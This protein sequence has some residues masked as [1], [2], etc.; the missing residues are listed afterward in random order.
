MSEQILRESFPTYRGAEFKFSKLWRST[1]NRSR[2]RE[3]GHNLG[4]YADQVFIWRVEKKF[5]VLTKI[6]DY[7][8]EPIARHGGFDFYADGFSLNY[9]NYVYFGLT[10]LAPQNV[11]LSLLRAYQK[12]SRTP[13]RRNLHDLH[14]DLTRL[15][16]EAGDPMKEF[17]EFMALGARNFETFFDIESFGGSDELQLTSMIAIVGHWRNLHEED[18]A[19]THD[20][21][22]NFFRRLEDWEKI[23]NSN[24]PDQD[25]PTASGTMFRFPL[26]VV[27]IESVDSKT[28]SSVQLCDVLSGLA[29]RHFRAGA[30]EADRRILGEAVNAGLGD[31]QL[32]GIM[33]EEFDPSRL[34]PR[35]REG[36]DA[37][38]RMAD[39][40]FGPHN[41]APGR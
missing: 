7:L 37:V 25:H 14:W 1:R 32:G 9:T 2:F 15:A 41:R 10:R 21:S 38:D 17:L 19:I 27:S 18:F 39:I 6:V 12:F 22:S 28:N 5:A 35:E 3:F 13:T 20:A 23:S 30:N 4:A 34:Q 36:P 31:A 29:G 24:V 26:R 33:P 11:Y 8:V 16:K 40:I